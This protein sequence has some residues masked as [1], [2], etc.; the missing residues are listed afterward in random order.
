VAL[1][2]GDRLGPYEITGS[3]GAGGMGEVYRARDTRLGRSVAIKVLAADTGSSPDLRA[4]FEREARTISQLH[5]PNICTLHDVGREGTTD[6][7]VLEYLEGQTLADRLATEVPPLDETLA[8]AGQVAE[9]LARAHQAGVVHRDLKP[10]NIMLLPGGAPRRPVVKLLDFGLAG[11]ADRPATVMAGELTITG[12]GPLTARGTVLGTLPYM[13]PEQVEGKAAD[14]RSDIWAFG[15]VLYEMLTGRRPFA[16]ETEASL[17]GAI[18]E[19]QPTPIPAITPAVPRSLVRLVDACVVKD[20]AGRLQSAHDARLALAWAASETADAPGSS[21]RRPAGPWLAA[22]A[23]AGLLVGAAASAAWLAGLR[24]AAPSAAVSVNASIA[25]PPGGSFSPFGSNLALS[26]DGRLLVYSGI[27]NGTQRLFLRALDSFEAQPLP[28]TEG[29]ETPFFS[30]DG[31]QVGFQAGGQLKRVALAGGS[32]AKIVDVSAARGAVWL[33][34]DTIVFTPN[35]NEGLWR[36]AATGEGAPE[37]VTTLD[38]A[39]NERTHRFPTVLPDGRTLLYM[40]G[41]TNLDSYADARVMAQSVDGGTPKLIL[42]GAL[43][44]QYL[45]SGYLTYHT[46]IALMMVPFDPARLEPTGP[47]LVLA[48][49][50]AWSRGFGTAHYA[51]AGDATIAYIPGGETWPRKSVEWLT[52]DGRRERIERLDG[53]FM[54]VRVDPRGGHLVFQE[55]AANDALWLFDLSREALS[56]LTFAGN[57]I[58]GSWASS[59]THVV[60]VRGSAIVRLPIDGAGPEDLYDDD[61]QKN[62]PDVSPDGRRVVFDAAGAGSGSDLVMLDVEQRVAR[63]WQAERFNETQPRFSPDGRRIAYVSD[64]SGRFEVFVRSIEGAGGRI[65]VSTRGGTSPVWSRDGREIFFVSPRSISGSPVPSGDLYGVELSETGP[66]TPRLIVQG[67]WPRPTLVAPLGIPVYSYD[68]MPDG[69]FV[70]LQSGPPP[71]PAQIN[72]IVRGR[73]D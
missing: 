37:R 29:A 36:I 55:S 63:P 42:R 13:A 52:R 44:P 31:R 4:R 28:G 33:P 72:V 68:V 61:T 53:F 23:I 18:L 2:T 40:A 56:R 67:A 32:P 19:R 5:H 12:S 16:G 14:P 45:R 17:I 59:G 8:I 46:G 70:T 38:A 51:A 26:P 43:A 62:F 66:G 22:A 54:G 71:V 9:A 11:L 21:S 24:T 7:L 69:R 10:G 20:A 3:L 48:E 39:L 58:L 64:E 35:F 15:C 49:Q 25:L 57:Y 1:R 34:D 60:A 41:D 65:Q 73:P 47:A 27:D 6:F 30:P 50:V